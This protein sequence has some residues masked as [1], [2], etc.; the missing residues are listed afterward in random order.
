VVKDFTRPVAG[1][2][3]DNLVGDLDAHRF[4]AELQQGRWREY[5]A[6]LERTSWVP[7]Y[8]H[9]HWVSSVPDRPRWLDEWAAAFP[10]SAIPAVVRGAHGV[11]WAWQARGA[12]RAR[13]VDQ[14]AWPVFHRRL[15]AADQELARAAALDPA[16]PTAVA[17]SIW[18]AMGL[19]LGQDEVRRR[20]AAADRRDPLNIGACIAMI[21]AT[22]RKWGGSHE[23][24]FD[25]AR[26]VAARAP[27][28]HSVHRVIALAHV[29]RWLDLP[30]AQRG[31]YFLQ[32]GVQAEIRQAAAMSVQSAAFPGGPVSLHDRNAF[33][34]CFHLMGDRRAML[35]EMKV[36]AGRITTAPWHF[37]DASHPALAYERASR[38][39][40]WPGRSP[41]S[42][43]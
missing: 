34:F 43:R 13:T 11:S 17:R 18:A 25:F 16:D 33:A 3:A 12:G 39:S 14:D 21:Q 19:E 22:A 31:G 41:R 2:T 15:I 29:E 10:H 1:P 8:F 26:S 6:F 9:T 4:R 32:A 28:G 38:P 27:E 23:A 35:A 24:M 36:I 20:F 30:A 42:G 37:L 40:R 5:H 7:R